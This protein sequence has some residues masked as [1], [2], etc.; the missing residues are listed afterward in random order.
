MSEDEAQN[1]ITSV[2]AKHG[3]IDAAILTVGGFA[4]GHIADFITVIFI[5]KLHK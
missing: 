2:V 5:F 4:M 1:L 3:S